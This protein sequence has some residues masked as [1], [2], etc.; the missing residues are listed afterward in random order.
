MCGVSGLAPSRGSGGGRTV[1]V[2]GPSG[3]VSHLVVGRLLNWL[4]GRRE[5]ERTVSEDETASLRNLMSTFKGYYRPLPEDRGEAMR[6]GLIV[7]DTNALLDLY[8]F[9][10]S[11]REEL[12]AVIGRVRERVFVPYQVAV[13]FHRSRVS[14]VAGRTMEFEGQ[15]S[16][17]QEIRDQTHG[18]LTQ[19]ERRAHD[20]GGEAEVLSRKLSG[21][22]DE[23]LEFLEQVATAYGLDP[24]ALAS[25]PPDDIVR[26]IDELLVGRVAAQPSASDLQSD[27]AEGLRRVEGNIPPGFGDRKKG[28]NAAGDYMWW[29]E[30]LRYS[31]K[32]QPSAVVLVSND[33]MKGDWV[34]ESR[35]FRVGPLPFLVAEMA[36][37]SGAALYWATTS[38]FLA[39]VGKATGSAEVSE[40]TLQEARERPLRDATVDSILSLVRSSD[41]PVASSA[42][43]NAALRVDPSLTETSWA[44]TGSFRSFL[45]A[46]VPELRFVL[47]P[48]P[49]YV[50]DPEQHSESDLPLVRPSSPPGWPESTGSPAFSAIARQISDGAL[51]PELRSQIEA[52]SQIPLAP[53]MIEQIRVASALPPEVLEALR[54][55]QRP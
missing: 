2:T 36:D 27:R 6:S 37:A 52:A 20:H 53:E 51:T 49:G 25:G 38:D 47:P 13:E 26:A 17:L 3:L 41:K 31:A 55:A 28:D 40:G 1:V 42:V 12:L 4:E 5:L 29:A 35:G 19:L 54:R 16:S 18:L 30:V 45:G 10:L 21:A 15:R 32:T 50:L 44:G 7:F 39:E 43:A 48:K 33:I 46:Y 8:R 22:F 24:D 34:Y 23:T 14:A 9:S 11:A